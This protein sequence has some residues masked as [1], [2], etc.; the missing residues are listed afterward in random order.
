MLIYVVLALVCF[1]VAVLVIWALRGLTGHG[2]EGFGRLSSRSRR[3]SAARLAHINSGLSAA[4]SPWGWS[5]HSSYRA[6]SRSFSEGKGAH[7]A[8]LS[9]SA[10]SRHTDNGTDSGRKTDGGKTVLTGYDLTRPGASHQSTDTSSWPYRDDNFYT[11]R[12]SVSH[13]GRQDKGRKPWGW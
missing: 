5:R 9:P 8:T 6:A 13:S 12:V 11:S 7:H 1:T 2:S 4:P 10:K 3:R